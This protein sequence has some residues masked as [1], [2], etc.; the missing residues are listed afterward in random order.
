MVKPASKRQRDFVRDRWEIISSVGYLLPA[1]Q[2]IPRDEFLA[3][4]TE[5]RASSIATAF[6]RSRVEHEK[7]VVPPE[8]RKCQTCRFGGSSEVVWCEFPSY[9]GKAPLCEGWLPNAETF[10][11][12]A[13]W[14]RRNVFGKQCHIQ[15]PAG[16]I[17]GRPFDCLPGG[18]LFVYREPDGEAIYVPMAGDCQVEVREKGEQS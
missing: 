6:Y 17:E 18:G 5:T 12:T 3:Q 1:E 8:E 16:S 15:T 4:L 2:K 11:F 14:H 9:W 10:I 13:A 7:A